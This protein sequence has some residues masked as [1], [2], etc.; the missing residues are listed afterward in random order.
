MEII[1]YEFKDRNGQLG[2]GHFLSPELE[3][4]PRIPYELVIPLPKPRYERNIVQRDEFG[5]IIHS[6]PPPEPL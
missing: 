4:S 1:K 6:A 5:R 2:N 3:N